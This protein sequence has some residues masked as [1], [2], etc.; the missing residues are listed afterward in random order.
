MTGAER[1]RLRSK[2]RREALEKLARRFPAEFEALYRPELERA[3]L[4][5]TVEVERPC[6]CGGVIRRKS[7]VG[8]WPAGCESCR[9]RNAKASRRRRR[10]ARVPARVRPRDAGAAQ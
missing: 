8:C 7:P 10:L 3:G 5:G 6:P 2:A 4:V 9:K 1:K